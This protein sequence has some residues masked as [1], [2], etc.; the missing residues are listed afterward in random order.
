MTESTPYLIAGL[1]NPGPRYR[2]NRHNIGFMVIDALADTTRIPIRRVE[3]RALVGKGTLE[4]KPAILANAAALILGH[5]HPSGDLTPSSADKVI[6]QKIIQAAEIM[7]IAIHEHLIISME[8]D[9]YYSF[10]EHGYIR[11]AYEAVRN[12]AA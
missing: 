7:G 3:F 5:N 8:D 12:A 6:T 2:K 10:A 11:E 4:N 9:G 1:G